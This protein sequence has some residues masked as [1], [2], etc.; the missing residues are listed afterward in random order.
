MP[1]ALRKG[2]K[3]GVRLKDGLISVAVGQAAHISIAEKRIVDLSEI[4]S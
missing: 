1:D 4:L 3:A 2:Q